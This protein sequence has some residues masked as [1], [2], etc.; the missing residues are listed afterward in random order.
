[1]LYFATKYAP[2]FSS[3]ELWFDLEIPSGTT[4]N[5]TRNITSRGNKNAIEVD[6]AGTNWIGE[7]PISIFRISVPFILERQES[8]Y[9]RIYWNKRMTGGTANA[10]IA[11]RIII[12]E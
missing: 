2:A 4:G 8:V 1:V 3:T 11:P 10:Y 9:S 7:T 6:V 5:L 12:E